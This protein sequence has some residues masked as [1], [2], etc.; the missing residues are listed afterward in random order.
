MD[1]RAIGFFDSGLG[2]LTCITYL[3][4]ELPDERVVYFGDTAR[5][6]YGSKAEQTIVNFSRQ[7]SDFLVEQDV[8]MIVTACNTVSAIALD[9]LRKRHADIPVIGVIEPTARYIAENYG[10]D[11]RIGVLGTK[12]TIASHSYKEQIEALNSEIG[13]DELAC[14]VLV[15]LIEEGI[16]DSD[17][18]DLAIKHYLDS[19]ISERGI[20]TVVLGCTHYPIIKKN[21]EYLYPDLRIINPSK[22]VVGSIKDE[23][24]KRDALAGTADA[25]KPENLFYA[26]D[27]SDNFVAMI[28]RIFS[29]TENKVEFKNFDI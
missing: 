7:I 22:M 24:I 8:K 13:I 6:P 12:V 11:D 1:N 15:P 19:F 25:Q 2:G 9:D 28:D 4:R 26:S 10:M 29:D 20:D 21:I 23:L 5:T 3:M 14:P 16:I 17:I 18:M 27:L